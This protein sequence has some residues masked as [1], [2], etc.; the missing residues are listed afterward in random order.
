MTGT[1]AYVTNDELKE[2][3]TIND[4][5]DDAKATNAALSASRLIDSY[6]G[7]PGFD[8]DTVA[9]A[10]IYQAPRPQLNDYSTYPYPRILYVHDFWDTASLI[11]QTDDDNDGTYETTWSATDY[12]L[13]PVNGIQAGISGWPYTEIVTTLTR[14]W[15]FA[16][17]VRKYIHPIQIT[18]KWGWA[19][20]PQA[21]HQATLILAS[22]LFAESK[23]PF[24]IDATGIYI[25]RDRMMQVADMLSAF[26]NY[27]EVSGIA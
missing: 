9:T 17:Y 7:R 4:A 13:E 3:V 10:R 18:A 1:G 11:V 25:G 24:G 22:R 12:Q 21:V 14:I 16:V 20:V 19:A 26:R 2:H 5:R 8:K 15:P 27:N 23:V 6:C